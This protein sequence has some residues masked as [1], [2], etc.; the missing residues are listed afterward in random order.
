MNKPTCKVHGMIQRGA[1]CSQIIVGMKYCGY[2]GECQH[3]VEPA[4][5]PTDNP[6]AAALAAQQEQS[7]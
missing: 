2:S 7:K 5:E 1:M 6:E 4:A 3:K